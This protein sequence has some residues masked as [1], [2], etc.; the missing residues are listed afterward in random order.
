MTKYKTASVNSRFDHLYSLNPEYS[1]SISA[2]CLSVRSLGYPC[3]RF[4]SFFICSFYHIFAC[5]YNF[6]VFRSCSEQSG[7]MER[8]CKN[9]FIIR[10]KIIFN[11]QFC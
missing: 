3:L 9:V 4:S 11:F 1:G 10:L 2:H 7:Q 8:L 5:E 6:I